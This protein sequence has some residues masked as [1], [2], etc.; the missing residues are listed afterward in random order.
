MSDEPLQERML[1]ALLGLDETMKGVKEMIA[2]VNTTLVDHGK[3][4]DILTRD[5]IKGRSEGNTYDS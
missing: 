2:G 1:S 5:A 4:F 3:K